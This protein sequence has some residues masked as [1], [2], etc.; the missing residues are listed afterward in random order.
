MQARQLL[1]GYDNGH[2]LLAGS[3]VG[4]SSAETRT[5]L[6]L[7]DLS[8]HSIDPGFETYF[9]FY[10]LNEAFYVAS[11]TWYASEL[12]R[13]GCVWTHCL[14]FTMQDI[15]SA[16]IGNILRAF[17]RPSEMGT[18]ESY[19][20]PIIIDAE[21]D[22]A[23]IEMPISQDTAKYIDVFSATSNPLFFPAVNSA[24]FTQC[25]YELWAMLPTL[26]SKLSW[27]SG[28]LEPRLVGS[29]LFDLQAGP[30]R[31]RTS[32]GRAGAF[33]VEND[34]FAK[35]VFATDSVIYEASAFLA[36]FSYDLPA[37]RSAIRF[38][39]QFLDLDRNSPEYLSN[40]V[41][42]LQESFPQGEAFMRGKR[43]L[44]G[45][46]TACVEIQSSAS[47]W[48]TD[49]QRLVAL[50]RA[51]KPDIVGI[52]LRTFAEGVREY[53][54]SIDLSSALKLLQEIKGSSLGAYGSVA[55]SEIL[56]MLTKAS[57]DHVVDAARS[58]GFSAV[59]NLV[60]EDRYRYG[61]VLRAL[62][63]GKS[64]TTDERLSAV[65]HAMVLLNGPPE[66][67]DAS[68]KQ[69]VYTILDAFAQD[70][71]LISSANRGWFTLLQGSQDI[72]I[73]WFRTAEKASC[74]IAELLV[75]QVL[76]TTRLGREVLGEYSNL[77]QLNELA[78]VSESSPTSAR[79][80]LLLT[81]GL[82][83]R[84]VFPFTSQA[85]RLIF[86]ALN[87]GQIESNCQCLVERELPWRGPSSAETRA[88][89]L[90]RAVA[91]RIIH[92]FPKRPDVVRAF[93]GTDPANAVL[94]RLL[95]TTRSGRKILD[96]AYD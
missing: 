74:G 53:L 40:Y 32:F 38:A 43:D 49:Q 10:P 88:E 37:E 1:F 2:R 87:Q 26:K 70:I 83:S 67:D 57:A 42:L 84:E 79:A 4:L 7:S 24:Q 39:V 86:S 51:G 31:A 3:S 12:P 64:L 73:R 6:V 34:A 60:S 45:L 62:V 9:T 55:V 20:L 94:T 27:C 11:Q 91:D 23:S 13:P 21:S 22:P 89:R 75:Q 52:P 5:V 30:A 54:T 80:S 28:S 19:G 96:N 69:L 8:G 56:S 66:L 58:V 78:A 76:S 29:R 90:A 41:M 68:R 18:Y 71:Q 61:D 17:K 15:Q 48:L 65:C 85:Y 33:V 50:S 92:D 63:V 44:L 82:R 36:H 35:D 93:L 47:W 16:P 25:F 95:S 14:V 77:G 72:V 46:P 59:L 81:M